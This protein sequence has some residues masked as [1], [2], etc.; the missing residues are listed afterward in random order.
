MNMSNC[1]PFMFSLLGKVRAPQLTL[2]LSTIPCD[3]FP[4]SVS[5]PRAFRWLLFLPPILQQGNQGIWKCPP[6]SWALSRDINPFPVSPQCIS[7]LWQKY[8]LSQLLPAHL[9]PLHHDFPKLQLVSELP[10]LGAQT[11]WAP[12]SVNGETPGPSGCALGDLCNL[13][14]VSLSVN[15]RGSW[16]LAG[17]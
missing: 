3:F 4:L 9:R 15:C 17:S 12:H 6:S 2:K 10:R 8:F 7:L 5:S 16:K 14:M 1:F 11:R 13:Q